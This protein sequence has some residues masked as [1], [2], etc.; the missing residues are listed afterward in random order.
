MDSD[1]VPSRWAVKTDP[2]WRKLFL[3]KLHRSM[4]TRFSRKIRNERRNGPTT[5]PRGQLISRQQTVR[6]ISCGRSGTLQ[7]DLELIVHVGGYTQAV[8]LAARW[9]QG[10]EDEGGEYEA[11]RGE[12]PSLHHFNSLFLMMCGMDLMKCFDDVGL[13][14]KQDQIERQT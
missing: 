3:I 12:I 6:R 2:V 8:S 4:G 11:G 13:C 1:P 5:A 9:P 7:S 14:D 10:R